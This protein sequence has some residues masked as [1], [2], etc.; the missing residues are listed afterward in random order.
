[1][2]RPSRRK[3]GDTKHRCPGPQ[4]RDQSR[5]VDLD[6]IRITILYPNRPSSRFDMAYYLDK[7]MPASIARLSAGKGFRCVAGDRRL[8]PGPADTAPPYVAVCQYLFDSA[9]DFMTVF[10]E[11]ADHLQG[12][13]PNYTDIEPVILFSEVAISRGGS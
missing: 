5:G 6:M 1:V 11:H 8:S 12:D 3:T 7:H 10:G 9:A 13:S 4:S 2:S